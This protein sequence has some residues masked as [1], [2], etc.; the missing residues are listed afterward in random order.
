MGTKWYNVTW[1]RLG[2]ALSRV[3]MIHINGKRSD[4][5]QDNYINFHKANI[6][7]E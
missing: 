5:R 1:G 4:T 3:N 2:R 6:D 7:A